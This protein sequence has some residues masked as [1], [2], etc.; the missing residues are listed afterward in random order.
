MPASPLPW[1]STEWAHADDLDTGLPSI[2]DADDNSIVDFDACDEWDFQD[3][4][5]IVTACNAYPDL[6]AASSP[7]KPRTVGCGRRWRSQ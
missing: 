2:H 6:K 5:Y 3:A 4:A 7:S 1:R